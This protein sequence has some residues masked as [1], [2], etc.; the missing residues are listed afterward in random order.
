MAVLGFSSW[1]VLWLRPIMGPHRHF[2]GAI[3]IAMSVMGL[4]L[5]KRWFSRIWYNLKMRVTPPGSKPQTAYAS[6]SSKPTDFWNIETFKVQR[7]LS[8]QISFV[9]CIDKIRLF[10]HY[11]RHVA[12][13]MMIFVTDRVWLLIQYVIQ[14]NGNLHTLDTHDLYMFASFYNS[15][16]ANYCIMCNI[17]MAQNTAPVFSL[18]Y[19][20]T[21][22]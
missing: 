14:I 22:I 18:L 15:E 1:G 2:G 5:F 19:F 21:C 11:S 6:N 17:F 10:E 12:H 4:V 3:S 20:P 13:K 16:L 9:S 7:L 8:L